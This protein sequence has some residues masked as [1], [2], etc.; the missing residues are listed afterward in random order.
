MQ[1]RSTVNR[2]TQRVGKAAGRRGRSTAMA[3]LL[4][5][6]LGLGGLVPVQAAQAAAASTAAERRV[7]APATAP[8]AQPQPQ[9]AQ[10]QRAQPQQAQRQASNRPPQQAQRQAQPRQAQQQQRRPQQQAQGQQQ[11]RV[12]QQPA[13][14]RPS[15]GE[16]TGLRATADDLDLHSSVA[17]VVDQETEE[18]LFEKNAEAVLPIASITKLMTALVII[19][20]ELPLNQRLTVTAEDARVRAGNPRS[21]LHAGARLSRE[22]ALQLALMA[23]ENRAAYLLGRTYPGGMGAFVQAMNAKARELGMNDTRYVE[24][25]G[26]SADNQSSAR[27]LAVLV[28]AAYEHPVI[29]RHSTATS[30]VMPVGKRQV[31]FR[32]TNGL[33]H[34]PEWNIGVQKTGYIAAAGRCVAL[35]AELA[36]RKVIVVLLDSAGRYAR[37]GDAERLRRWVAETQL[38]QDLGFQPR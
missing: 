31:Q 6:A 8:R 2:A 4:A 33:V 11:R 14:R 26:L 35:Q 3:L 16:L 19:E 25:T 38:L 30:A 28:R 22:S 5:V 10:P 12:A 21:T 23:S 32:T 13:P 20:S 24:P 34:H 36:G 27:D 17:L 9:R 29:R 7:S 37:L 15:V 18:V 1:G